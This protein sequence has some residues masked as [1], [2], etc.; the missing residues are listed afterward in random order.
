MRLTDKQGIQP[1]LR[2]ALTTFGEVGIP[3]GLPVNAVAA[4][5]VLTIAGVVLDSETVTIGVDTY[6]FAA[7][8]AQSVAA[9]N[10]AVDI[11]AHAVKAQGTLTVAVQPIAGDTMTIDTKLYTFVANG[12]QALDGDISVGAD[13]P[14]AKLN[15]VA[16]INGL[17][18]LS[19]PNDFVTAGAFIVND[20]IL[21]ALVGGVAGNAIATTET[22]NNVGNIFDAVLL[23]TTTAGTDCTNA[24]GGTELVAEITASGTEPL[25][26][27][28]T[29][30]VTLTADV[31]GVL[32]NDIDTNTTMATGSFANLTLVGGLDG[33]VCVAGAVAL[34]G[35]RIYTCPAGNTI[36]QANWLVT[37]ANSVTF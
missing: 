35:V 12:T 1:E 29:D 20:C 19:L 10:I 32:A 21:T 5:G 9:G 13:L 34:S 23:G 2:R 18:L 16:A 3:V 14:E 31:R 7:D 17:D 27:A 26:A 28:G 36:T 37:P 11:Q 8:A 6:E 30:V 24:N 25:T 4:T 22:F 33:T 15:I